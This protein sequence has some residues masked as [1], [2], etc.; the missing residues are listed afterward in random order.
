MVSAKCH[1]SDFLYEINL[2][3]MVFVLALIH[4]KILL[5]PSF[6]FFLVFNVLWVFVVTMRF[7]YVDLY[8]IVYTGN[9]LSSNTF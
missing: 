3:T 4:E 7:M 9:H 2:Q 6:P 1:L 5:Y 8:L